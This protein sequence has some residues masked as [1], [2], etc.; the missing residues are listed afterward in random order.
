MKVG[1]GAIRGQAIHEILSNTKETK[2]INPAKA[3]SE[4][5]MISSKHSPLP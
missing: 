3:W 5:T 1:E 2:S 4:H